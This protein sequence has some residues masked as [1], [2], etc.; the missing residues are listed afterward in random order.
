MKWLRS[1]HFRNWQTK[2]GRVEVDLAWDPDLQLQVHFATCLHHPYVCFS[3][4]LLTIH[5]SFFADLERA[6]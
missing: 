3:F 6:K 1:Y 5:F 4:T 2:S